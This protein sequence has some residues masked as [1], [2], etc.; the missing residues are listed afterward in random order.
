MPPPPPTLAV[1]T[2][3]VATSTSEAGLATAHA[4][5]TPVLTVASFAAALRAWAGTPSG[6]AASILWALVDATTTCPP[7]LTA[8]AAAAGAPN[9][10]G[11]LTH[12]DW[13]AWAVA[14]RPTARA[15]PA[16]AVAITTAATA[17]LGAGQGG[18][19]AGL[20]ALPPAAVAIRSADGGLVRMLWGGGFGRTAGRGAPTGRR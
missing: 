4:L 12:L 19:A 2:L 1:A 9:S 3:A 6:P 10:T 11:G 20:A 18:V 8:L 14:A 16:T 5:P 13:V 7:L 17:L 15:L